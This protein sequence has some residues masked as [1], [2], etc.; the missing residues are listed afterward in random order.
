MLA[1]AGP[2]AGT[3]LRVVRTTVVGRLSTA[4]AMVAS[5]PSLGNL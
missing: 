3:A 5:T 1:E 4:G 2:D